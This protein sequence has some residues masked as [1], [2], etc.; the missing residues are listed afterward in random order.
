MM[1]RR[2]RLAAGEPFGGFLRIPL[3][4]IYTVVVGAAATLSRLW[5]GPLVMAR[6]VANDRKFKD[7]ILYVAERC[8]D[9]ASFGAIKLNKILYYSDFLAYGNL[10]HPITGQIYFRLPQG[11]APKY[12]KP[13]QAQMV[14]DGE[15]E[16]AG[17]PRYA[18]QQIRTIARQKADLTA[19]TGQEIA[20]VDEVID[21]LGPLN[22]SQATELSHRMSLGWQIVQDREEI[23]YSTIFLSDEVPDEEHEAKILDLA[24]QHGWLERFA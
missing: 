14:A 2:D 6:I 17:T 20:L 12:L 11:P 16:L 9:D 8:A 4:R 13:I 5:K 7:L 1:F 23:P 10:G 19:F 21:V 24:R 3:D 22:A 15:I 18:F